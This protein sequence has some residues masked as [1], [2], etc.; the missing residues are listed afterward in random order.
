MAGMGVLGGHNGKPRRYDVY[1]TIYVI[2][3]P[4]QPQHVVDKLWKEGSW[5]MTA[6]WQEKPSG[7]YE[8]TALKGGVKG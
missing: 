1:G 5:I 2:T 4:C 6:V 3:R 7:E 8:S